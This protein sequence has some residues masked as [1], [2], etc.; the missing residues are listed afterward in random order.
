MRSSRNVLWTLV[1]SSVVGALAACGGDSTGPT[2]TSSLSVAQA[3]TV[4]SALLT[5]MAKAMA[6]AS[7]STKA[8]GP[9]FSAA[10]MPSQTFTINSACTNGGTITGSYVFNSD[11]GTAGTGTV[12]GTMTTT[13]HGCKVSTGS[14][15]IATD[16]TL[17]Y[18]YSVGYTAFAPSSN[19]VWKATGNISWTGGSCSLDYT[20]SVSTT[21]HGSIT[22]SICGQSINETI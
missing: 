3:Q 19:F 16:G 12:S 13:A 1:L 22:G 5:E 2:S 18:S 21:G 7:I 20:A 6:S 17:N 4:A 9:A 11:L 15:L 8:A 10:S 14:D